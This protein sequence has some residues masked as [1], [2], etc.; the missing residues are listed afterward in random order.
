MQEDSEVIH[1]YSATSLTS[2]L[3][4]ASLLLYVYMSSSLQYIYPKFKGG[5]AEP[6]LVSEREETLKAALTKINDHFLKDSKFIYGDEISV[7]DLLALCELTQ[8][9]MVETKYEDGYPNIKRWVADCQKELGETFDELHQVVYQTRDSK[10]LM[11]G[12]KA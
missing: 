2:L 10:E 8:F 1:T 4:S 5:E 11:G 12:K 6:V 9:W 3:P 7:A